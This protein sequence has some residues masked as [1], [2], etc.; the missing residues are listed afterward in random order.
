[1]AGES[2]RAL[3]YNL[4]LDETLDDLSDEEALRWDVMPFGAAVTRA[5]DA[6]GAASEPEPGGGHDET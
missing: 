4:E 3:Y 2:E 1:M 5:V 6:T